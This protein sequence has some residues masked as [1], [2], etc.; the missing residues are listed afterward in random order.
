MIDPTPAILAGRSAWQYNGTARPDFA[1]P[2]AAGQESVWDYPRPPRQELRPEQVEIRLG[3]TLIASSR[4]AIRVLETAS[5]PTWYLP[6]EDVHQELLTASGSQSLCEWKGL[7]QGLR[8]AAGMVV[9]GSGERAATG[10]VG[11]RYV[12]VFPEFAK[13]YLWYAFYPQRVDCY[14]AG[15]RMQAQPGGYYGGWVAANMIGPI[16]GAPGSSNW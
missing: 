11:W 5:A 2:V 7:A 13:L 10:D 4:G 12:R 8:F 14:V 16:K 9:D 1:E 3:D 15:E 6:P